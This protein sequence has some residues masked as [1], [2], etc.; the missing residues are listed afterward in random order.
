MR[1]PKQGIVAKPPVAGRTLTNGPSPKALGYQW[2]RVGGKFQKNHASHVIGST[3]LPPRLGQH[4]QQLRVIGCIAGIRA[5]I[6]RGVN[7]GRSLEIGHTKPRIFGERRH[8]TLRGGMACLEQCIFHK[9]GACFFHTGDAQF[10]LADEREATG[11]KQ[12]LQL[13]QLACITRGQQQ[14][15]HE[16]A[17]GH[18]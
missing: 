15:R 5:G 2:R 3:G 16:R 8:T 11:G 12:R 17:S 1:G 14:G 6:T 10:R 18:S 9:G 7:A 4:A 13:T